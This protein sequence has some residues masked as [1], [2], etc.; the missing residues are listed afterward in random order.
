MS[1]DNTFC[2]EVCQNCRSHQWNTRHD[3]NKYNQYYADGKYSF[4]YNLTLYLL[5]LIVAHA[6]E[7]NVPGATVVKNHVPKAWSG[8]DIYC[9]LVEN[10]DS[11]N[12]YYA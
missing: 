11:Q 12:A 2:I 3:E 1:L 10:H 8:S 7:A 5:C 4:V 9:Q 6:I